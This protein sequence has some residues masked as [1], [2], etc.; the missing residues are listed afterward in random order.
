MASATSIK[1]RTEIDIEFESEATAQ[2]WLEAIRNKIEAGILESI[3][4][5]G[6]VIQLI[7]ETAGDMALPTYG[8]IKDSLPWQFQSN[9]SCKPVT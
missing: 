9:C 5:V 7:I 2:L 1:K 4:V 8:R 3:R 6:N